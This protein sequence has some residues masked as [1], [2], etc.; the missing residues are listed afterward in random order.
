MKKIL[1]L[2]ITLVP[3]GIA[4]CG[5]DSSASTT[6]T[7]EITAT[8][9]GSESDMANDATGGDIATESGERLHRRRHSPVHQAADANPVN[10][11]VRNR[12]R[13]PA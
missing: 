13:P 8:S 10:A 5:D 6:T 3:L 4:A 7:D 1:T 2:A 12:R 11:A 9:S